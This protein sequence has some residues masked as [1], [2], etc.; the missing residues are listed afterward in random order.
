M[1]KKVIDLKAGDTIKSGDGNCQIVSRVQNFDGMWLITF[2][3]GDVLIP[4]MGLVNVPD[5]KTGSLA[6]SHA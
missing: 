5:M 2:V 6:Y 3:D 4:V 1:L